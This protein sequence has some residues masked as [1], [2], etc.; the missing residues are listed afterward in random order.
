[1]YLWL[2]EPTPEESWRR[3]FHDLLDW[4]VLADLAAAVPIWR[5]R[6]GRFASIHTDPVVTAADGAFTLGLLARFEPA[7]GGHGAAAWRDLFWEA[8]G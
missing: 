4:E 2:R 3:A 7:L 6:G 8:P 5:L 1:M